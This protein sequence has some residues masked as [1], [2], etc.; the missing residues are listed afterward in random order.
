MLKV[1]KIPSLTTGAKEL[2]LMFIS[3]GLLKAFSSIVFLFVCFWA[4]FFFFFLEWWKIIQ[5]TTIEKDPF[6]CSFSQYFDFETPQGLGREWC[7]L[8]AGRELPQQGTHHPCW[9]G[10]CR[11]GNSRGRNGVLV[12]FVVIV[13]LKSYV[14]SCEGFFQF[15]ICC[16]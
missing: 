16:F 6:P 3:F 14:E 1:L 2:Q 9:G 13:L 8:S 12:S 5:R 7:I 15:L 4:G 10:K 11:D